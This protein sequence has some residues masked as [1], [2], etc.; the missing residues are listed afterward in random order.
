[1]FKKSLVLLVL[2]C[3]LVGCFGGCRQTDAGTTGTTTVPTTGAPV[4]NE[5]DYAGQV[6]LNMNSST[7]KTEATVKQFIDGDTTHF[8]VPT[9]VM[10]NGVLKARYIAINTPESTGKIEEWGKA[11]AAF[12]K[13]KLSA[14]TSIILE[15]EVAFWDP[16]STGDRYLCWVWYRTSEDA[17]Y[18]NLNIE[19]LQEGLAI[20]SNSGNNRYGE[21]CLKAID[22]AKALKLHVF[23]GQKDPGFYYGEAVELTLKELRTNIESYS[24]QKVAFNGVIT[25]NDNN[26]IYVESLDAETGLYFGMYVYYGFNLSA[27]GLEILQVG[28][29]VRIV[30]SVQFYEGGGT[31]QVSDVSYRVMKPDDPNNLQKLSEG[32]QPSYALTDP[33]T[34]SGKVTI[35]GE[36]GS[37]E[38]PYAQLVMGTSLAMKDLKVVDI[39]TTTNEDSSSKGAMTLTCQ[40][41]DGSMIDV[42]TTVLKD[43]NG[44][45]VTADAYMGKT[46]DIR[47]IVD[48]YNGA[49]QIKVFSTNDI[50]VH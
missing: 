7:A 31:W 27:A 11:A 35:E 19:I 50:T 28:N 34:F 29:E 24:G 33:A 38:F 16:D 44:N 25:V 43:A 46:I 32:N 13:E 23:S 5:V 39:Y 37:N 8:H 49:Y 47:G 20:A 12:T 40:A 4:I 30:G 17:E 3:L 21:I 9:S 26:G 6:K 48:Y 2:A 41:P 22:Q 10:P 42:R 1:M 36:E 45:T 18:R 15:S 14:A